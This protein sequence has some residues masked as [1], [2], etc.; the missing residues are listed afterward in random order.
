MATPSK[1]TLQIRHDIVVAAVHEAINELLMPFAPGEHV[2]GTI[3][4]AVE[5]LQ[6]ALERAAAYGRGAK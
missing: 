5:T 3:V 2:P 1:A 4:D 6:T